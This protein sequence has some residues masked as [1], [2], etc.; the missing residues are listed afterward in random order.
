MMLCSMI[1]CT[2][3]Q[4]PIQI[5]KLTSELHECHMHLGFMDQKSLYKAWTTNPACTFAVDHDPAEAFA[6][7]EHALP[8]LKGPIVLAPGD[9][10][11]KLC[12]NQID[13]GFFWW[14]DN[15]ALNEDIDTNNEP[16]K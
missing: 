7:V 12:H 13:E 4:L 11:R 8:C 10:M 5:T 14:S 1:R 3:D 2:L 9:E 16:A 15:A 6:R